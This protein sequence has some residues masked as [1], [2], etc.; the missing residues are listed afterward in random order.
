MGC[1]GLRRLTEIAAG[2]RGF[3][4]PEPT[5][6][7]NGSPTSGMRGCQTRSLS[8]GAFA[9]RRTRRGCAST[10]FPSRSCTPTTKTSTPSFS[11][12]VTR[13]SATTQRRHRRPRRDPDPLRR[14]EPTLRTT[15]LPRP[16]GATFLSRTVSTMTP[17][18]TRSPG[19]PSSSVTGSPP[20]RSTRS[21]GQSRMMRIARSSLTPPSTGCGRSVRRRPTS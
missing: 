18:T 7:C 13:S 9:A 1:Q 8:V 17:R 16:R 12:T 6:T 19:T 3:R 15:R 21:C 2:V 20:K 4:L 14:R 5:R 11:T 10:A